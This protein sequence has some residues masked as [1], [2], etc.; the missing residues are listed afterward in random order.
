[1]G[2][3]R[4]ADAPAATEDQDVEAMVQDVSVSETSLGE[5]PTP[6]AVM[7]QVLVAG[8]E[9]TLPDTSVA[10]TLNVCDP[11]ARPV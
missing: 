11:A 10:R 7:V 9:S 1:V 5:V 4:R 8:V 3:S 6:T 2:L